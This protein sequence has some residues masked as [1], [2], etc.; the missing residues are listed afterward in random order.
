MT[1]AT[2][3]IPR[4]LRRFIENL[5]PYQSLLVLAVP[6]TIVE[7]LKLVALFV[8]GEGHFVAGVLFMICAYA[9]SLFVTERLFTIV[10]PKLLTLRWFAK[11]WGWF[12][13]IRDTLTRWVRR[14][15]TAGT[16]IIFGPRANL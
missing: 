2:M 8:L 13:A 6:L 16:Q 15:W 10:K 11:A 4:S 7:P 9:G 1:A 5:G 14:K 12:V 3:F